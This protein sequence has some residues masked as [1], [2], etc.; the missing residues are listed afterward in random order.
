MS[1]V[2]LAAPAVSVI[3]TAY[4]HEA[5]VGRAIE[6]VLEQTGV[7]FE[8]LVGDD[9]STDGTR[10]EIDRYARRHPEL[11]RVFYPERNMGKGGKAI[12]AELI[13]RSRGEYIAG[14]DGDDYWTCPDKLRRQ[15]DHLDAHPECSLVFHNVLR[16]FE[17]ES[18]PDVLYHPGEHPRQ[19]GWD[20]IF[21]ENP[22]ASVAPLFRR[23]VLDPLPPSY[24]DL[25]WGDWP[26]YFLAAEKGELH[27]MP[28]VMAVYR[29]HGSGMY[30]SISSL[31]RRQ[32]EVEFFTR[33]AELVP[34]TQEGRR[35]R[36]LAVALAGL[37]LG[38]L[39]NRERR[40]ARKYVSESFRAWPMDP[41][42]WRRGHGERTRLALWLRTRAPC[43]PS[44]DASV[45]EAG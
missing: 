14:I 34:S 44:E 43:L 41:W 2:H 40:A 42:R 10:S 13:Q 8:L 3:I 27:Y 26:H 31:S 39:Q 21:A 17:D 45:T 16:H 22:V 35:R 7:R 28:E 19:I 15:V 20:E 38:H 1:D 32:C 25:P 18:Q 5:Y 12:W 30:S 29:V 37:A 6:G 36:R 23:D 9:C 33:L 24:F 4:N 11:I